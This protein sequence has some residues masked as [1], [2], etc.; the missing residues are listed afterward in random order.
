M[1][2]GFLLPV[3][4]IQWLACI[5]SSH[6]TDWR[7][8]SPYYL[9]AALNNAL[10]KQEKDSTTA[11]KRNRMMT[12]KESLTFTALVPCSLFFVPSAPGLCSP[13]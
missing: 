7:N 11:D 6:W 12:H 3:Q 10:N 9:V 13:F 4:P 2:H 8:L 5:T 1:L